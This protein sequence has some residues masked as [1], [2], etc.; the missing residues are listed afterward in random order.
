MPI[1]DVKGFNK[2]QDEI[3]VIDQNL[4]GEVDP[5]DEFIAM[6]LPDVKKETKISWNHPR[7]KIL[8]DEYLAFLKAEEEEEKLV[9]EEPDLKGEES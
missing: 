5:S 4:N 1:I 7:F 9:D 6:N 2:W 3:V 8:R